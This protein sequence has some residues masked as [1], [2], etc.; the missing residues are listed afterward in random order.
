MHCK[1]TVM[2]SKTIIIEY[3]FVLTHS[4]PVPLDSSCINIIYDEGLTNYRELG[5]CMGH[6]IGN[7]S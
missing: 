4:V 6:E 5:F 1:N 3:S 2:I 7:S